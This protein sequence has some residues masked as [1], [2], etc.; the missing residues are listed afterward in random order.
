[1]AAHGDIAP[2]KAGGCQSKQSTAFQWKI[3]FDAQL[4]LMLFLCGVRGEVNQQECEV[5]IPCYGIALK[6]HDNRQCQHLHVSD[7]VHA[8]MNRRLSA[9]QRDGHGVASLV[10]TGNLPR[11]DEA[12]LIGKKCWLM[13]KCIRVPHERH[14]W[15]NDIGL[16]N[17]ACCRF[18]VCN[19]LGC[20]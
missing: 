1:V 10:E 14:H 3:K 4:V 17:D 11:K 16:A 12:W 18:A 2:S 9:S 6:S 15:S 7:A 19:A 20:A 13:P 5:N 8:T